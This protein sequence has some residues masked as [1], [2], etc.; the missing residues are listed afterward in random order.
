MRNDKIHKIFRFVELSDETSEEGAK[1]GGNKLSKQA[2]KKRPAR[3]FKESFTLS[4]TPTMI[5]TE[6]RL[7]ETGLALLP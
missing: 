1:K 6:T 5:I 3:T 2:P 4:G 7:H